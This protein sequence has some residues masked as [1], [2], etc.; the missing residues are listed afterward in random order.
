ML[1]TVTRD[2]TRL[3]TSGSYGRFTIWNV[4][5]REIEFSL[6]TGEMFPGGVAFSPDGSMLVTTGA[7][8]RFGSGTLQVWDVATGA[9]LKK[10]DFGGYPGEFSPNGRWFAFGDGREI[11][12]LDVNN[13]WEEINRWQAHSADIWEVRWSPKGSPPRLISAGAD[14]T[15]AVWD[16]SDWDTS[17]KELC[18][19]EGHLLPVHSAVFSPDGLVAATTSADK[20]VR[21]WDAVT[22]SEFRE[23]RYE[24]EVQA[25]GLAWSRDGKWVASAAEDGLVKLRN[26]ETKATWTLRGHGRSV[27]NVRF[28]LNSTV[29]ITAS[30]D[31][32]MQFW[33]LAKLPAN[34]ALEG[35]A[36][37][38][39]YSPLAF[40]PNS[41][42]VATVDPNATDVLLWNVATGTL[43]SSFPIQTS[44]MSQFH[45]VNEAT[46][47][48]IVVD[49]L[50]FVS[51]DRLAVACEIQLN[52]PEA[53]TLRHW[54]ALYD[55]QRKALIGG[56][57]GGA[58]FSL[59]P[60]GERLAMQ[61]E[62]RG[63]VQIRDLATGRMW[64][65]PNMAH[66]LESIRMGALAFSPDGKALAVC[67]H[68]LLEPKLLLLESAT[69]KIMDEFK[70][71]LS[72]MPINAMAFT[73]DGAKLITGG[74]SA[75]VQ[76]WDVHRRK[77][78][79]GIPGHTANLRC[80]AVLPDGKTLVTG[81]HAG[82][83]K[84][85]S[86]EQGAELLTLHAHEREIL[87][88]AFAP[89]GNTLAS[90]DKEGKVKLWRA[91]P[92]P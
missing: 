20:T 28:A 4:Q 38:R 72:Q 59:S 8:I 60:D 23:K 13:D 89:D 32:T 63:S 71:A 79:F 17:D 36:G 61:G 22:G 49:D 43:V 40:S 53:N 35:R 19:L 42:F 46:I 64:P 37:S 78:A 84:F 11:V 44:E 45:S 58:P 81:S 86:L 66:P 47:A 62:A 30:L 6:D 18:R 50:A 68:V 7:H 31:G 21:F 9:N 39:Y 34:D 52:P 55:L 88:V 2:G 74:W 80:L 56:F 91:V 12:V 73:R 69:G 10:M 5:T 92:E 16:A 90:G 26:L 87:A 83:L 65:D 77:F 27:M 33:D 24:H 15:A 48:A 75:Q 41:R 25:I 51:K 54:I 67:V 70:G 57:P 14:H 76:V 1:A 85:W 82:V 29:L 3:A